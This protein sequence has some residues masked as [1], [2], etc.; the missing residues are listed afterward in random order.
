MNYQNDTTNQNML[1]NR[2]AC[3]NAIRHDLESR[4]VWNLADMQR[5]KLVQLACDATHRECTDAGCGDQALAMLG[6][7]T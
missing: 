4:R 2:L 3:L 5:M 6:I 7:G 1:L